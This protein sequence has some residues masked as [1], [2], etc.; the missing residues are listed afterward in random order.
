MPHEFDEINGPQLP[1]GAV[2]ESSAYTVELSKLHVEREK[3]LATIADSSS[4][5]K[6][7]EAKNL[8]DA[9]NQ[10]IGVLERIFKQRS[11]EQQRASV[12]AALRTPRVV[13]N[14][15]QQRAQMEDAVKRN[16]E[17]YDALPPEEKLMFRGPKK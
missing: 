5:R 11:Y 15:E 7:D 8:L 14:P 10:K 9:V 12:A 4:I 6:R 16:K 3:L 1:K 2:A 17:D 13:L